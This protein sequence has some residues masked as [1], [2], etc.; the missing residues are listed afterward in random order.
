MSTI[1][2]EQAPRIHYVHPTWFEAGKPVE[3]FVCGSSLDHPK[4]RYKFPFLLET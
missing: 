2:E 4:F 3:L 1:L